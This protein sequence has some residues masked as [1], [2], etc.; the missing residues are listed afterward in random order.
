MI[1]KIRKRIFAIL[2][3]IFVFAVV[4]AFGVLMPQKS[5]AETGSV[6]EPSSYTDVWDGTSDRSFYDFSKNTLMLESAAQLKGFADMANAGFDFSPYTV[7]LGV[8]VDLN[9]KDWAPVENFGGTFDGQNHT[10]KN[11]KIVS[12]YHSGS[13]FFGTLDKISYIKNLVFREMT[14]KS[15]SFYNYAIVAGKNTANG[16]VF[17]NIELYNCFVNTSSS[18]SSNNGGLILTKSTGAIQILNCSV[19]NSMYYGGYSNGVVA[20]SLNSTEYQSVVENFVALNTFVINPGNSV[21]YV[22]ASGNAKLKNCYNNMYPTEI[23]MEN[24]KQFFTEEQQGLY[25]RIMKANNRIAYSYTWGEG[26]DLEGCSSIVKSIKIGEDD[27]TEYFLTNNNG[28]V[29]LDEAVLSIESAIP[30]EFEITVDGVT[31]NFSGLSVS[32]SISADSHMVEFSVKISDVV[33]ASGSF[34]SGASSIVGVYETNGINVV[35]SPSFIEKNGA[36][37]RVSSLAEGYMVKKGVDL[38]GL[39]VKVNGEVLGNDPVS[40]VKDEE[41]KSCKATITFE[42]NGKTANADYIIWTGLLI[43]Q[44]GDYPWEYVKNGDSYYYRSTN[45]DKNSTSSDIAFT[46]ANG[47]TLSF[48]YA[49]SSENNYDYLY[50]DCNGEVTNTKGKNCSLTSHEAV[51]ADATVWKTFSYTND[52]GAN[53]KIKVYYKKDSSSRSGTDTAYLKD[54][55]CT[56]NSGGQVQ[57]ARFQSPSGGSLRLSPAREGSVTA[58]GM[59]AFVSLTGENPWVYVEEGN[60]Y[61]SN[62]QDKNS[63]KSDIHIKVPAHTAIRINYA[64][65]SENNWDYLYFD[66]N[67]KVTNTKGKNCSLTSH[68]AVL[69]D[70]KVWNIYECK[71]NSDEEIDLY[72]YYKKDSSGSSG[73]D[74]AYIRDIQAFDLNKRLHFDVE[75][76]GNGR[77]YNIYNFTRVDISAGI[78]MPMFGVVQLYGIADENSAQEFYGYRIKQADGSWGDLIKSN[79]DILKLTDDVSVKVEFKERLPLSNKI[80]YEYEKDGV[81]QN[82]ELFLYE[83]MTFDSFLENA[84]IIYRVPEVEGATVIVKDPAVSDSISVINDNGTYVYRVTDLSK[85]RTIRFVFEKEGYAATE[86]ATSI[87]YNISINEYLVAEG[88]LPVEIINNETFNFDYCQEVSDTDK[89]AFASVLRRKDLSDNISNIGLKVKGKGVLVFDCYINTEVKPEEGY[90]TAGMG[91]KVYYGI[92]TKIDNPSAM[93]QYTFIKDEYKDRIGY[94]GADLGSDDISHCQGALGWQ[95]MAIPVSAEDGAE[96]TVYLAYYKNR[97]EFP[98]EDIV[99]IANVMFVTGEY[100]VGFETNSATASVSAKTGET[101]LDNNSSVS[102]GSRVTFTT[103]NTDTSAHFMGWYDSDGALKSTDAT[104][105]FS[106]SKAITLKA[107]YSGENAKVFIGGQYFATLEEAVDSL[108]N[109]TAY[110]SATIK[111]MYDLSVSADITI[112]AGVTLLL[113]YSALDTTGYKQN[114]ATSARVSWNK[115]IKP[116]ITVTI[117]SGATLTVNGSLK[118]GGVQH[119]TDQNAQGHTSGDYAQLINNGSLIVN[120]NMDVRGLVSGSGT[121]TVNSGAELKQPFM[122]NNYSGGSNT[123]SLYSANQFPFV[124]FATVNVQCKQVV[125]Y[126]AKVVGST[127]LFFWGSITTQDVNLI[128]A[129]G[130]STDGTLIW[131]EEG[132]HLEITYTN[133][134]VNE[135]VGNIHLG[136]SGVCTI[137]V[138]GKI[139]AG[140]FYLQGYGSADMVLA[141]PYTYNFVLKSGATVTMAHKY[142]IMPGAVVTVDDGA[143]LNIVAGGGLYVYDGLIQSDKSGK[144]Y[145]QADVLGAHGFAKSGMLTVN[146]TLNING[147]F[148]G[149]AQTN[150]AGVINVAEG[151]IV[152]EQ[153]IIDGC[154]GGYTDNTTVFMMSGRIYGLY[155]FVNLEAGKTYKAFA[156]KAFTLETFTVDSAARISVLTVTLNQAMSGRFLEFDGEKFISTVQFSVNEALNG[157]VIIID[158]VQYT[159]SGGKITIPAMRFAADGKFTYY[160][161]GVETAEATHNS[162]IALDAATKLDKVV[163]SVELAEG[164]V[165]EINEGETFVLNAI[166]TYNGGS[167][168][169]IELSADSFTTYVKKDAQLTS[170]K[171]TDSFTKDLYIIRTALAD[172]IAS[173]K[174]LS[175]K[176]GNEL[177][178]AAKACYKAYGTLTN[179]LI[180]TDL[181]YV[182]GKIG[183]L[184]NYAGEIATAV[185]VVNA[186]AIIYG[187]GAKTVEVIL[188]FINGATKTVTTEISVTGFGLENNV[189]TATVKYTG[190][191]ANKSYTLG[192]TATGVT[193]YSLTV[194]WEEDNFT[195]NGTAQNPTA[196]VVALG[197]DKVTVTVGGAAINAGEHT[198]TATLSGDDAKYYRIADGETKEFEILAKDATVTVVEK[199]GVTTDNTTIVFNATS[200]DLVDTITFSY[201]I[202][203]NG[204]LVA[205]VA[206]NG[207]ITFEDDAFMT[208]DNSL[209]P[210]TYKVTAFAENSN[211]NFTFNETTFKVNASDKYYTVTFTDGGSRVFDGS[212]F[213]PEVTANVT[214]T[215]TFEKE[216]VIVITFN[217]ETVANVRNAGT[218][219]I[220]VKVGSGERERT[221]TLTYNVTAKAIE[222]EWTTGLTFNGEAQKPEA[223]VKDGELCGLD[224]VTVNVSTE[225]SFVNVGTY[226]ATATLGGANA[227]NYTI[228][229][230]FGTTSFTI[231]PAPIKLKINDATSVYGNNVAEITLG[232]KDGQ[233]FGNDTLSDIAEIVCSVTS[234]SS[235]GKYEITGNG[236]NKNYAITFEI[237]HYSVTKRAITVTIDDKTSVYGEALAELTANVTSGSIVNGDENVYTL[238]AITAKNVGEY[239]ITTDAD[240][241]NANYAITVTNGIYTI[242]KR[243]ITVSVEDKSSVYGNEL[244]A[245]TS[246][247]KDGT[248][249][250]GDSLAAIVKLSKEAG[251]NAGKYAITAECVNGNYAVKFVYT[252]GDYSVYTIEK[253]AIT[254]TITDSE[255]EYTDAIA[256]MKL[257]IGLKDGYTLKAGETLDVLNLTYTI[258]QNGTELTEKTLR[259]GEWTFRAF[260]DNANYTVTFENADDETKDYGILSITKPLIEIADLGARY[261]YSGEVFPYYNYETAITVKAN[262]TADDFGCELYFNGQKVE[263]ILNAGTYTVRVILKSS[264][265]F[266]LKDGDGKNYKDFTVIVDKKDITDAIK[267]VCEGSVETE[268][269]IYVPLGNYTQIGNSLKDTAIGFKETLTFGGEVSELDKFG[270]Y[271]FKVTVDDDNYAGEKEFTLNVVASID[272]KSANLKKYTEDYKANKTSAN[273]DKVRDFLGKLTETDLILFTHENHAAILAEAKTIEG[274]HVNF[275]K[276]SLTEKLNAF[277]ENGSYANI[278]TARAIVLDLKAFKPGE[279]AEEIAAYESAWATYYENLN[280]EAKAAGGISDFLAVVTL[281]TAAAAATIAA[282]KKFVL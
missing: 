274:A 178:D 63:T 16:T 119:S 72:I 223:K 152:G 190:E 111:V 26:C 200:V 30:A 147:T 9:G 177:L 91:D 128:G 14:A 12:D 228:K 260:Y 271:L 202:W 48:S 162:A 3:I 52:T 115:G 243:A 242:T 56:A 231:N 24:V 65:S 83:K 140:E 96:S 89:I 133:K 166:V 29:Y 78:E 154:S 45:Q 18:S 95:R 8:N 207:T 160:T 224:I 158:G 251:E 156:D 206:A 62:N 1:A 157:K 28:Y 161:D 77:V 4:G 227:G 46:V 155:G 246:T 212:E 210:G 255:F 135:K 55:T 258:K 67:G 272:V 159:V 5:S 209:M 117:D 145:P 219:E 266:A 250:E 44:E 199:T 94:L 192:T 234:A 98:S 127:S 261:T 90:V 213:I 17:E 172:Y 262:S 130:S 179:D 180:A 137:S 35:D 116:F 267:F 188:T 101:V 139:T 110:E 123:S 181:A 84:S 149:I 280:A 270:L 124:Q 88:S 218:Y 73:T 196:S 106:L 278:L 6:E 197:S 80:A 118:V 151:A 92:N 265:A 59:S 39:T 276:D 220:I 100:N 269:G 229:N 248:I 164:N 225:G 236:I 85:G 141:I 87:E 58:E 125:N 268:N 114:N 21:G 148:A 165:Y 31:E 201:K 126:G 136:D 244:E 104:Y 171:L 129:K 167:T 277:N 112:P 247:L 191:F 230:T 76:S 75:I 168:E 15:T 183:D 79:G 23:K 279:G 7:K 204:T 150:G 175:S 74:T 47:C 184:Q 241:D 163:I 71:N 187:D 185:S 10:I 113:P 86:F 99:A 205:T 275:L 194:T 216:I 235:V 169:N 263:E 253:R 203:S 238:K 176:S 70:E 25:E 259:G 33:V 109:G 32:K 2:S 214:G 252:M 222:I 211:Y 37:F 232:I 233:L 50:F 245:L 36:S 226:T 20:A 22:V 53:V 40:L 198:A 19:Y 215:D 257:A 66:Y 173:V 122:V 61:R 105:T 121:L 102:A 103:S 189:I 38:A 27:F 41:T 195:Y 54:I 13:G 81:T 256:N 64:C 11:G 138:Y 146:G 51:L 69:A 239:V 193:A 186:S 153:T 93:F 208:S 132:S 221:Y 144:Q 120:G 170:K 142:K 143:T 273:A 97:D 134:T 240:K 108:W 237:G 49:C 42:Y 264:V 43:S 254:L 82:G 57:S 249:V 34:I 174:E 107:V 60:Y 68:E 281:L 282:A 131:M 182:N 217:G